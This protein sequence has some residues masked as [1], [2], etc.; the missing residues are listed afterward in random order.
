MK[1]K[2]L[3]IQQLSKQLKSL[4]KS[5]GRV[6]FKDPEFKLCH[7]IPYEKFG[8]NFGDEIGPAVILG[9]LERHFGTT[10]NV[11]VYNLAHGPKGRPSCLFNLGSIWHM[12]DPKKD[13]VWGTGFNP[14]ANGW[15]RGSEKGATEMQIYAVRGPKSLEALQKSNA[16]FIKS[17]DFS[18]GDPALMMASL[19]PELKSAKPDREVCFVPHHNDRTFA[20]KEWETM[21]HV[22]W[23]DKYHFREMTKEITKCKLVLSSSLHGLIVAEAYGIPARW[24]QFT[25]KDRQ[26]TAVTE[27]HFKYDDYFLATGR[28]DINPASTIAEGKQLGGL[29]PIHFDVE[30]FE[31]SFPYHLFEVRE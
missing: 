5:N 15:Q 9:L 17:D 16:R 10:T 7:F 3:K 24:V 12:I 8:G 31:K 2:D 18:F 29:E 14:H 27:G 13:S 26:A 4:Q 19:W 28:K 23:P 6:R 11:P 22:F 1:E 21:E 25:S 30:K 20:R